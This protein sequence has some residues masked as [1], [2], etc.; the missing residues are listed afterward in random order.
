MKLELFEP[1]EESV[2]R[3]FPNCMVPVYVYSG[4]WVHF[5]L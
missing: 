4:M 2:R 1:G 3:K 5:Q